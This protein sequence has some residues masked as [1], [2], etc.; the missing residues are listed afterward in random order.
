MS[1]AAVFVNM[2]ATGNLAAPPFS[3]RIMPV[4]GATNV[5]PVKPTDLLEIAQRPITPPAAIPAGVYQLPNGDLVIIGPVPDYLPE[6][7][8]PYPGP[9]TATTVV[10]MEGVTFDPALVRPN[11]LYPG[12][13][14]LP[15]T[16]GY[17]PNTEI[18]VVE[19]GTPTYPDYLQLPPDSPLRPPVRPRPPSGGMWIW[20]G[21]AWVYFSYVLGSGLRPIIQGWWQDSPFTPNPIL[22]PPVSSLP[23]GI[24]PRPA[25]LA[26]NPKPQWGESDRPTSSIRPGVPLGPWGYG[27][28]PTGF[29][30]GLPPGPFR[31]MRRTKSRRGSRRLRWP[32]SRLAVTPG[33]GAVAP[34]DLP[35]LRPLRR[36]RAARAHGTRRNRLRRGR[37]R[38]SR[39]PEPRRPALAFP[40]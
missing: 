1:S 39:N 7:I 15:T 33:R 26:P 31:R 36:R 10:V 9:V 34:I 25:G 24:L 38:P 23:G 2:H 14:Q 30:P 17:R 11:P 12:P 40:V 4:D 32:Q 20:N 5:Q 6:V 28:L 29:L 3:S 8:K 37:R 21:L 35:S 19:G 22:L 18:T 13:N 16:G 27:G